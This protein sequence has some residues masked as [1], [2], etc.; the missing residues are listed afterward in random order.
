MSCRQCGKLE[1]PAVKERIRPY[2][3]RVGSIAHK[4]SKAA[5]ISRL[6]LALTTSTCNP[7][8]DAAASTSL[9]TGSV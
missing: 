3:E 1:T 9:A 8:A 5:S 7:M 4:R 6:S 2:Q